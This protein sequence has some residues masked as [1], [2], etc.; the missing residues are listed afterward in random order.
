MNERI[1]ELAMECGAWTQVYENIKGNNDRHF[2]I[3]EYFNVEKF[4]ELI[5]NECVQVSLQSSH[6]DDDM[7]A[8]NARNIKKH[9]GVKNEI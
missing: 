8:I 6:R 5:V 9:F 4:A 3:N 1:K 2:M 7:S